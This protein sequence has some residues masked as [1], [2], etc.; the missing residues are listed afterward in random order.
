[1][2]YHRIGEI[3]S[4]CLSFVRFNLWLCKHFKR[5]PFMAPICVCERYI[6]VFA[7]KDQMQ[8]QPKLK[9]TKTEAMWGFFEGGAALTY[10]KNEFH[11]LSHSEAK[12]P[13]FLSCKKIFEKLGKN[14]PL[15]LWKV[16]I[17]N[18]FCSIRVPIEI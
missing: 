4:K 10:F 7:C 2:N 12:R 5:S 11:H 6:I 13:K 1:M 8:Y 18:F 17:I 14:I 16:F 15:A 9:M 3:C